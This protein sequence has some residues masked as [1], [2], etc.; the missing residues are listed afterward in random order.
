MVE[1]QS[2]SAKEPVFRYFVETSGGE[3]LPQYAIVSLN[4][5]Y[6]KRLLKRFEQFKTYE[7]QDDLIELFEFRDTRV[8]FYDDIPDALCGDDDFDQIAYDFIER[9][10]VTSPEYTLIPESI[11]IPEDDRELT[12][13]MSYER[14]IVNNAHVYWIGC[15]KDNGNEFETRTIAIDDLITWVKA[16]E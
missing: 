4:L 9:R 14:V 12:K 15:L 5:S 3:G 2:K 16:R 10:N 7:G 1:I 11:K 8:D 13:R 6:V